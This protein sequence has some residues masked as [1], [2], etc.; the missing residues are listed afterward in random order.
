VPGGLSFAEMVG[1]LR[2]L[3]SSGRRV[4]GFDLSEVAPGGGSDWDANVGARVLYKLIGFAL[5]SQSP[6]GQA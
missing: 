1:L 2:M 5:M 6:P 4:V 3:V